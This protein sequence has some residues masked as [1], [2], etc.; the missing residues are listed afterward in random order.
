MAS[1]ANFNLEINNQSG[2]YITYNG[3][4]NGVDSP[5]VSSG[6][7]PLLTPYVPTGDNWLV[8]Q[9]SGGSYIDVVVDPDGGGDSQTIYPNT[10]G[11]VTFNLPDTSI[12]TVNWDVPA[13]GTATL[14]CKVS[15]GSG[16]EPVPTVNGGNYSITVQALS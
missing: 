13:S 9:A 15:D 16:Y 3:F 4:V 14:S 5:P 8:V 2:G 11:T 12:L 6:N 10:T 7:P 1:T